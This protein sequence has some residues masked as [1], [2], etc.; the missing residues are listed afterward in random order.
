MRRAASGP[1]G[2]KI[3][4]DTPARKYPERDKA[5]AELYATGVYSYR[6]IAEYFGIHLATVGKVGAVLQ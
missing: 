5:I 1:I 3:G 4:H 6:E 2:W